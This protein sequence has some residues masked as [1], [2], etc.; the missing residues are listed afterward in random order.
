MQ[1]LLVTMIGPDTTCDLELPG[2][3]PIHELLPFLLIICGPQ[4]APTID[5]DDLT[6]QWCV[7]VAQ[8]QTAL[9]HTVSFVDAGILDGAVLHL[10]TLSSLKELQQ[11]KARSRP[12]S[13]MP[14]PSSGGIG[15]TWDRN[16]LLP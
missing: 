5:D 8:Q 14:G 10:Q 16:E 6:K 15:V 7:R 3:I 13:I 9:A 2:D 12:R 4:P 11:P 1:T